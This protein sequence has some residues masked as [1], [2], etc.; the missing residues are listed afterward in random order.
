MN[1]YKTIWSP[2]GEPYEIAPELANEL[3]LNKGWSNVKPVVEA[4]AE[5]VG[6]DEAPKPSGKVGKPKTPLKE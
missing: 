1:L 3:V 4:P 6:D 2:A 5:I